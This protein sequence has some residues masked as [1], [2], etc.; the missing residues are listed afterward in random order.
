M[1]RIPETKPATAG[2]FGIRAVGADGRDAGE[3]SEMPQGCRRDAAEMPSISL[4]LLQRSTSARASKRS[5]TITDDSPSGPQGKYFIVAF[6]PVFHRL[7]Q[8]LRRHRFSFVFFSVFFFNIFF[9]VSFFFFSCVCVCVAPISFQLVPIVFCF[10]LETVLRIAD[11]FLQL[12]LL[13][14]WNFFF[15]RRRL[16]PKKNGAVGLILR[17][18]FFSFHFFLLSASRLNGATRSSAVSSVDPGSLILK[19]SSSARIL[20]NCF[21]LSFSWIWRE[22]N[23]R[24]WTSVAKYGNKLE[25]AIQLEQTLDV[26]KKMVPNFWR[27]T[28][29]IDKVGWTNLAKPVS[30]SFPFF[31]TFIRFL[32]LSF[33]LSFSRKKKRNQ[34]ANRETTRRHRFFLFFYWR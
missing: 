4:P 22:K 13:F 29:G 6:L 5:R 26:E 31:F 23:S 25:M 20:D 19:T 11:F 27:K 18:F 21:L 14:F 34:K 32:F 12:R 1:P 7:A 8:H 17:F 28:N 16:T 9:A 33:F 2:S 30:F 3:A 10:V 24:E 15:Y